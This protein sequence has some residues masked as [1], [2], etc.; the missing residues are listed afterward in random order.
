M[1]NLYPSLVGQYRSFVSSAIKN[2]AS[3]SVI[4][5]LTLCLSFVPPLPDYT[6][7][8]IR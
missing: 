3:F 6:I 5:K 7:L 1:V 2:P 4:L 8:T